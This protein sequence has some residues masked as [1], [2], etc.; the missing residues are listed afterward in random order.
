[1]RTSKLRSPSESVRAHFAAC[2]LSLALL[3]GCAG[4]GANPYAAAVTT[5]VVDDGG[6]A[7]GTVALPVSCANGADRDLGMGLALLHN[8]TYP[9]ARDAFRSATEQD[10]DCVLGYWGQA[11]TFVHPM[12][13][14][15]VS[16]QQFVSGRALLTEAR[17][18]RTLSARE[19][20]YVA[21]LESYYD[22]EALTEPERLDLL[23]AGW[24]R[25]ANDDPSDPEAALFHSLTLSA[26]AIGEGSF[27]KN[28]R[29][30]EIAESVVEAIPNHPG[31]NHY[32]I[33]AYDVP[34]FAEMAVPAAL[35]YGQVAVENSHAQ[36]MTSHIFTR[37]GAWEESVDHNVRAA[38]IAAEEPVDGAV[39]HHHFHA[40]DYLA[41]AYLQ[42]GSDREAAEIVTHLEGIAAPVV[43]HTAT[44]YAFAAVPTRIVLENQ[45]WDRASEIPTRWPDFLPWDQFPHMEAIP[46][47]GR[48]LGAARAGDVEAARTSLRRLQELQAA[49]NAMETPYDWGTAVQIQALSAQAWIA[50]AESEPERAVELLTEAAELELGLGKPA[51]T[52]G[53]VLPARELLGD[54]L[55]ELGRYDEAVAA[56]AVSLETSPRRFNSLYGAG[57]ASELGEDAENA[58]AYYQQLLDVVG[59]G[60]TDRDR[61]RHARAVVAAAAG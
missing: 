53:E 2:V 3:A 6:A 21:A 27:V 24:E 1:M 39:S 36:H 44:A 56:Y 15:Q 25:A 55:L 9:Q 40:I 14:D 43:V 50:Y 35:Q 11:M 23:S 38:E 12:W 7:L 22:A 58:I 61:L 33:H 51:V 5:D 49:A 59:P 52:P 48:A 4:E 57:L 17:D 32:I 16:A 30:G 42:R 29:A 54:L 46:V 47:F 45:A 34:P 28:T 60:E 41:Y 13:P 37:V 10:P 31:A 19:E 26:D 20:S 8:M 18:R